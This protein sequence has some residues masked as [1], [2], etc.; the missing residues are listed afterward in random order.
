[1]F[2]CEECGKEMQN[3]YAEVEMNVYVCQ[4]CYEKIYTDR[5]IDDD[6]PYE[7]DEDPFA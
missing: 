4:E 2:W 7:D 1:M 6:N 3:P 5:E